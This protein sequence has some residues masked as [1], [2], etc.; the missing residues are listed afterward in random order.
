MRSIELFAGAG[1]LA[2]GM[3]RAGF[4]HSAVVEWDA[5]ACQ[6]IRENLNHYTGHGNDFLLFEGDAKK[7][8]FSPYTGNVEFISGGPPCQPFSL[9]GKHQGF[10]DSRD[11]FPVAAQSIRHIR[12]KA[13][14]FENVKGLLRKSFA[15]YLEYIILQFTYPSVSLKK[16]E[17]WDEHLARLEKCHT[18]GKKKPEY[19]VVFRLL[20]A[21]DYGVPQKRERVFIVGFR[22]DLGSSGPF[23]R[24]PIPK[25]NCWHRNGLQGNIGNGIA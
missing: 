5:D 17:S 20:N 6:T 19:H 14:V 24:K 9:G 8:N 16:N 4:E 12:P 23:R 13:F 3:A 10:S 2:M 1:G 7:F 15:S 18:A 21:A 25:T 22:A 11:M